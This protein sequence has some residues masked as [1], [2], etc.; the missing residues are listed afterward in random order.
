MKFDAQF[1]FA[2]GPRGAANV[3]Q[4]LRVPRLWIPTENDYGARHAAWVDETEADIALGKKYA[5]VA[6][7]GGQVLGAIVFRTDGHIRNISMNPEIEGRYFGAFMLRNVEQELQDIGVVATYVDTKPS[8]EAML[9]FLTAQGYEI[10][11]VEDLYGSGKPDALLTKS[12]SQP[13]RMQ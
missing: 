2:D 1:G 8:N 11:G 10:T 12:L 7:M 5:M 9:G 6:R 4:I 13:N 3:A